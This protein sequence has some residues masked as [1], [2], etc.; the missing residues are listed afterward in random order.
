L[1]RKKKFSNDKSLKKSQIENML[2]TEL[3]IETQIHERT[4]REGDDQSKKRNPLEVSRLQEENERKKKF[5]TWIHVGVILASSFP[6]KSH[7]TSTK[8]NKAQ[9][10]QKKLFKTPNFQK[11]GETKST[12]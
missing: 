1:K 7:F 3:S 2:K 8:Q 10:H 12:K 4:G 11:I 9:C 5:R 6:S